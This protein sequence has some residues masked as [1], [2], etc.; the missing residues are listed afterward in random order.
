MSGLVAYDSSDEDEAAQV[1]GQTVAKVG[2][3]ALPAAQ[4]GA[5]GLMKMATD[6]KQ[7]SRKKER[8]FRERLK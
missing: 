4:P 1:D 8:D 3:L 7:W 2:L 6:N 5:R